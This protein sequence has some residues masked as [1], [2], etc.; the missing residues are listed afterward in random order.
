MI[1][2]GN[3]AVEIA[4][5]LKVAGLGGAPPSYV[6][7]EEKFRGKPYK[8]REACNFTVEKY[9]K[10]QL[11]SQ[12]QY[13]ILT[14]FGP[15]GSDTSRNPAQG[16][17]SGNQSLSDLLFE[18]RDRILINIHGHMHRGAGIFNLNGV[19]V[20]NPGPACYG[21]YSEIRLKYVENSWTVEDI[22]IYKAF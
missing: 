10:T 6:G 13:L 1:L 3:Q 4:P 9:L 19:Y 15:L 17:E 8:T 21:K 20:V 5:G 18:F 22:Q 12:G 14:H 11:D 7:E 16:V 2:L